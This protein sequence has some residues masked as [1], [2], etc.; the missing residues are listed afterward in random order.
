[1]NASRLLERPYP[2]LA[3][4][5]EVEQRSPEPHAP[6]NSRVSVVPLP[7]SPTWCVVC[8]RVTRNAD[9][10]TFAVMPNAEPVNFWSRR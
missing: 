2:I 7:L 1:M 3:E 4:L 5:A 6:Q 8:P 9:L 10:G